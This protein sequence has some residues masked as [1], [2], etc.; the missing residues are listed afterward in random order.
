MPYEIYPDKYYPPYVRGA[1]YMVTGDV[2][3]RLVDTIDNYTGKILDLEDVVITGIIASKCGV[4]RYHNSLFKLVFDGCSDVCPLHK[5][6]V[7]FTC[8][9]S[10]SMKRLWNNW[11]NSSPGKCLNKVQVKS[12][13]TKLTNVQGGHLMV[14]RQYTNSKEH[15]ELTKK[16]P[17]LTAGDCNRDG[18]VAIFIHSSGNTSGLY[19]NRRQVIRRTWAQDLIQYNISMY[20]VLALNANQTV[21]EQL[22]DRVTDIPRYNSVPIH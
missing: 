19:Y 16:A 4:K 8:L 18:Q 21:N 14:H 13:S 17:I 7:V 10:K 9:N 12:A 5:A 11:I 6:I 2:V 15:L 22:R 1:V 3:S 20:F